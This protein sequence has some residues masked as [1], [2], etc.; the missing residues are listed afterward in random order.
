[1]RG[2]RMIFLEIKISMEVVLRC[3][4]RRKSII[5]EGAMIMRI[6]FGNREKVVKVTEKTCQEMSDITS[7]EKKENEF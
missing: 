5:L 2:V 1:M 3:F 4:K 7:L 6:L